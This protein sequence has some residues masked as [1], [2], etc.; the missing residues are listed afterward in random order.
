MANGGPAAGPMSSYS[1]VQLLHLMQTRARRTIAEL[2]AG[3]GLH[4]NTVRGHLNKLLE[5][6]YIVEETEQRTTRGRPRMF[7]SAATGAPD[8]SSAVAREKVNQAARRGDLMR[9][10]MPPTAS[11]LGIDATH[12]LDAL[13]EHLEESGFEPVI[14][15]SALTVDLSA[16]PHVAQ[17][18]ADDRTRCAVHLGLI[19]GVLTEAGGPLVADCV[20]AS[21]TQIECTVQL[22][23]DPQHAAQ[24]D[25]RGSGA[26]GTRR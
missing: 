20:R 7:Y 10:V 13:T 5:G 12:Q 23:V 19:Q 16:C 21:A 24:G 9:R 26:M 3:T 8:A 4:Q 18:T 6:G 25:A 22:R 11:R 14:D 1:R 17:R 15:D 2:C